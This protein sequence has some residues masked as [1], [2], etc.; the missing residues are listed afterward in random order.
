MNHKLCYFKKYWKKEKNKKI[1]SKK[2]YKIRNR[3][4]KTRNVRNIEFNTKY[5]NDAIALRVKLTLTLKI[6]HKKFT[7][8]RL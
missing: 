3:K 1:K 4:C 8:D 2:M 5:S 6:Q 7:T